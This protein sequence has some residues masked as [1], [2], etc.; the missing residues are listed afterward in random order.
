MSIFFILCVG[1]S[2][3]HSIAYLHI[4][5]WFRKFI[6]GVD[7]KTFYRIIIC[8]EV[9]FRVGFFGRLV[10][11]HAC[12]GFWVG[13]FLYCFN[14]NPIVK[15]MI[16]FGQIAETVGFAFLQLGFNSL[17]WLILRRLG[18]EEL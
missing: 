4:F 3:S 15:E 2:I 11:C 9:K 6:S 5:H 8:K 12:L 18:A 1:F 13:V 14:G 7:D 16:T 10:R 17:V